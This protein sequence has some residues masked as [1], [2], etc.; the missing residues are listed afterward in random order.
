MRVALNNNYSLCTYLYGIR[1]IVFCKSAISSLFLLL[2]EVK[3]STF[4]VNES[5]FCC[6]TITLFMVISIFSYHLTAKK[7]VSANT[8][9]RATFRITFSVFRL[10][11]S[12]EMTS[13]LFWIRPDMATLTPIVM[14]SNNTVKRSLIA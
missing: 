9:A 6:N 13:L 11:S 4:F 1:A 8:S 14:H 5:T 2:E 10:D 12:C 7:V 3:V